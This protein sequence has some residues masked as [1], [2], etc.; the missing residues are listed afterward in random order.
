MEHAL[1][2]EIVTPDKSVLSETVDFVSVPGSEGAFGVLP[3]HTP[4]LSALALGCL[5]Y[6]TLSGETKYVAVN[7]GFAEVSHDVV[8][9][10]ADSAEKAEEIDMNR[11]EEAKKRAEDRLRDADRSEEINITRADAALKRAL[12]RLSLK[13]F[14][15]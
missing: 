8:R 14:I 1:Q 7:G 12:N 15:R 6:T 3:G 2:L 13:R 10:L 11:A 4:F 9:I 5:H